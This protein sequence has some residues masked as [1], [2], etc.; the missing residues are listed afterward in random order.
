[1]KACL[2]LRFNSSKVFLTL[3]KVCLKEKNNIRLVK[4]LKTLL[5]VKKSLKIIKIHFYQKLKNEAFA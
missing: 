1:L 2:G 4:K 5:R 3:K